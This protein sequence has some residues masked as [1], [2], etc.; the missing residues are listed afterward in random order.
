MAIMH[1]PFWRLSWLEIQRTHKRVV[2]ALLGVLTYIYM[3]VR[4]TGKHTCKQQAAGASNLC[5]SFCI[6][7]WLQK[8]CSPISARCH[9]API[10]QSHFTQLT[11]RVSCILNAPLGPF[12]Q[13]QFCPE[14]EM[15]Y[16]CIGKATKA[17]EVGGG[18]GGEGAGFG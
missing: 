14:T 18:G 7:T 13:V 3:L 11:R 4:K 15:K 16:L 10:T 17:G 5:V 8:R 1:V 9:I 6:R 12:P 2:G